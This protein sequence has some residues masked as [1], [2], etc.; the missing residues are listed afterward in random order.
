MTMEPEEQDWASW[1]R[2]SVQLMQARNAAFNEKFDLK[3]RPYRWN[4]DHAQIA[5]P[6]HDHAVV[7]DLCVVG[8]V[9]ECEGTFLWAWANETLDDRARERLHEV[10]AFGD[11]HD[12]SLLTTAEWQGGRSEG[13][14][15]LAIAGRLLDAEGVWIDSNG[16]LTLFFTLHRFR[17][18]PMSD[19]AWLT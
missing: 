2:E 19:V 7:A 9:S 15:M 8:S 10:R 16:G 14:E 5:F 4:L 11:K 12:L 3:G 18:V 6:F 17:T 1:S 13:L